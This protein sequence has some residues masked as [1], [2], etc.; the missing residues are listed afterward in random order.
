MQIRPFRPSARAV[1]GRPGGGE[2]RGRSRTAS[3]TVVSAHRLDPAR[4]T[5]V[6]LMLGLAS[7]ASSA[8]RPAA[9]S[10]TPVAA[11]AVTF[12]A[13]RGFAPLG[14]VAEFHSGGYAEWQLDVHEHGQT[15]TWL[16]TIFQLGELESGGQELPTEVTLT[17]EG[18]AKP[19][20]S[21]RATALV[22]IREVG[23]AKQDFQQVALPVRLLGQGVYGAAEL[24]LRKLHDP[25]DSWTAAERDRLS[26][27]VG[28]LMLTMLTIRKHDQLE[29]L[30][31]KIVQKPSVWSVVSNFGVTVNLS[32][33]MDQARPVASELP[34]QLGDLPALRFPMS[35][36]VNDH[37][38][39][40][41]EATVVPPLPPLHFCGGIIRLAGHHPRDP[42][43]RFR[44]QLV[45]AGGARGEPEALVR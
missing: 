15:H 29:G 23:N 7:C 20:L 45:G 21:S 18:K 2:P 13:L 1:S 28:L 33:D 39:I 22:G 35:L 9:E 10:A 26:E 19:V 25:A 24:L 11:G 5:C 14:G 30:L 36:L 32:I 4:L 38:A 37:T 12:E 8:S 44:L 31:W 40:E 34:G 3:G 43:R 6:G 16:L 42:G 17:S 41:C 27:S